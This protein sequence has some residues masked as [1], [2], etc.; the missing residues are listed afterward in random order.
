MYSKFSK[1]ISTSKKNSGLNG[2][3]GIL[4]HN[5]HNKFNKNC[6]LKSHQ[7]SKDTNHTNCREMNSANLNILINPSVKFVS[8][9]NH[10]AFSKVAKLK[11]E[12]NIGK[13]FKSKKTKGLDNYKLFSQRNYCEF[14]KGGPL[15]R[16]YEINITEEIKNTLKRIDTMKIE[17]ENEHKKTNANLAKSIQNKLRFLWTY[18][19]NAIEGNKLSLGDTIFFLQEGLTVSGKLLKDFL[20]TKNH[21]DVVEYLYDATK[22]DVKIDAHLLRSINAFLLS[23]IDYIPGLDAQKNYVEKKLKAGEYKTEPNYVIQSDSTLCEYVEPFLVSMQIDDLFSWLKTNPND[24]HSVILAAITH[25]N[26]VRIH[27]FQDGNG[28][29][30]RILMN[31]VLMKDRYYPAIIET[32]K[33]DVYL[34]TLREGDKGDLVPFVNFVAESLESTQEIVLSEI[35]K[36]LEKPTSS[37]RMN[38]P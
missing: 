19:S 9:H 21:S 7:Q 22:N 15:I 36:F 28:R 34:D 6:T 38:K 5:T 16:H 8:K 30:A 18:N 29:C 1:N 27:P 23:G 26:L 35:N 13:E 32:K 17:I 4:T 14:F 12:N 33:R 25:Y 37:S 11:M 20:E 24:Y 10:F 2:K 31:L 3:S